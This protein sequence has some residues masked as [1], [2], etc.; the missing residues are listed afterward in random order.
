MSKW[1]PDNPWT[2]EETS[3]LL[4]L[5][6]SLNDDWK[7][8]SKELPG[9]SG[10]ECKARLLTRHASLYHANRR[11]RYPW[12]LN[13]DRVLTALHLRA[14][15]RKDTSLVQFRSY[16]PEREYDH[17]TRRR[18][19]LFK[20]NDAIAHPT[21][22]MT[23]WTAQENRTLI[24][25]RNTDK[26]WPEISEAFEGAHDYR[27]CRKQWYDNFWDEFNES[28]VNGEVDL[29]RLKEGT[30]ERRGTK[31]V[32]EGDT[33]EEKYE[34]EDDEADADGDTDYEDEIYHRMAPNPPK[35]G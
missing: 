6:K 1:Y 28:F 35:S 8:I 32:D 12:T 3:S 7:A 18:A 17:F 22:A 4:S 33:G 21:T 31:K 30:M 16:F 5:Y 2:D 26:S 24:D 23:E 11:M 14:L 13:E 29:E 27:D 9:R 20:S 19:A 10:S 15:H 34:A 25:L